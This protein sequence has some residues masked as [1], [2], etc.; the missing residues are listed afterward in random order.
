MKKIST[1]N[2]LRLINYPFATAPLAATILSLTIGGHSIAQGQNIQ[3]SNLG[4]TQPGFVING[5]NAGDGSGVTVSGAGDVNGDGLA[6]V[7]IGAPNADPNGLNS[8]G[9]SFVVFG[10]TD[11]AMVDLSNLGSGGFRIDGA[12]SNDVFGVSV[13][14]AGDVNGDGLADLIVGAI[15]ADPN[16]VYNAG[17]SFV[18]FGKTSNTTV[19]LNNLG[20]GGFRI[21][22][23]TSSI[24]SGRSVSGAGDVNGDGLADL[25]VGANYAEPTGDS[26]EGESYVV[27]GKADSSSIILNNLGSGGFRIEGIDEDDQSGFSVSGA[28][29]VNGDGLADLIVG[30]YAAD[31]NGVVLSGESYVIFGKS[32]GTTVELSNLGIGG[33]RLDGIDNSDRSGRS[34]SGAGDVNG[35]GL[36]DLIVGA[37]YAD[38]SAG[39]CYVVFGKMNL[40]TV[41]LD[42]LGSEGF[43]IDGIDSYDYAGASVSGAGDV[44]GDGLA[45]LIVGASSADPN[46]NSNA[47]ESYVVFGKT[48]GTPV[49]LATLGT[50]GFQINGIDGGDSSGFSVSGAGDVNGDGSADLIVG[51]FNADP[52]GA[53]SA[54]ESYVI[55]SPAT[56]PV[57]ATYTA[58]SPPGNA[59]RQAVGI[60]GDGSNDSTPDGRAF[61]DFSRGSII[62]TQTVT[63]T[64]SNSSILNLTDTANV[65]WQLQT[66]R[67]GWSFAKL[68]FIYT[69]TEIAGLTE[70]DLILYQASSP[71]GPWSPVPGLLLQPERNQISGNVS[72]LGYFAL[73]VG[74]VPVETFDS[75][76]LN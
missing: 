31:P 28:G 8:A 48:N 38:Y 52:N 7:I 11:G 63:L 13:S 65:L 19:S 68:T 16:G 58:M 72:T 33:F 41:D 29:D 56:P 43:R 73:S 26:A 62:S 15:L 39:E 50:G 60:T 20:T 76:R 54:G 57:S 47:G 14:G 18:I 69:D 44:N 49:D 64:R 70:A 4:T 67:T 32:N 12:N 2:Y 66:N 36:A 3:L 35:D 46:G 75:W 55:F 17:A 42:N 24:L 25:I 23:F 1:A 21:D 71:E 74:S 53:S 45:D 61:I 5:I 27:F 6:D 37:S 59:P 30:A 51:A 10:K 22:G 40:T 9:Q 34:V